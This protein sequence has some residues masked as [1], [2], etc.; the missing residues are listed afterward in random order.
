MQSIMQSGKNGNFL[1]LMLVL[2]AMVAFGGCKGSDGN[3][4]AA[5]AA[6]SDGVYGPNCVNCHHLSAKA[7]SMGIPLR[8]HENGGKPLVVGVTQNNT[9]SFKSAAAGTP[10][11]LTAVSTFTI[12]N[13]ST[14]ATTTVNATGYF[15]QYMDGLPSS[16]QGAADNISM[17]QTVTVTIPGGLDYRQELVNIALNPGTSFDPNRYRVVPI[18]DFT[19]TAAAVS[20]YLLTVFGDDGNVYFDIIGVKASDAATDVAKYAPVHTTGEPV[21]PINLPVLI[22]AQTGSFAGTWTLTRPGGSSAVFKDSSGLTDTVTYPYFTPDVAGTYTVS[23]GV[24]TITVYAGTWRGVITGAPGGELLPA[25]YDTTCTNA[26]HNVADNPLTAWSGNTSAAPDK[27][28]SWSNTG[29]AKRFTQGLNDSRVE[30]PYDGPGN[31]FNCHTVGFV[32]SAAK[33]NG[34]FRDQ[35]NYQMFVDNV[36]T[37]ALTA[38]APDPKRYA[39]AWASGNYNE[40]LKRSN[41][42]C[43]QCHGPQD[44]TGAHPGD[45]G[46]GVAGT[47]ISLDA[48]VCGLCHGAPTHHT[49]YEQWKLSDTGHANFDLAREMTADSTHLTGCAGCHTAQGSL[50]LQKQLVNGNPLQYLPSTFSVTADKVQP[51]TCAVCHDPHN[52]GT[53]SDDANFTP[54]QVTNNGLPRLSLL[55]KAKGLNPGDTPKLPAG[56]RATGVGD[57][58]QCIICHNT[59]NGGVGTT[60]DDGTTTGNSYLHED[61]DPKFG[62]LTSYSAPHSGAQGDVLM[63]H[64]AYFLGSS[65]EDAS[66]YRGN[67]SKIVD[68]CVTCHMEKTPPPYAWTENDHGTNHTFKADIAICNDCHGIDVGLGARL[69]MDTETQL[70]EVFTAINNVIISQA[71]G[72]YKSNIATAS[73]NPGYA[74]TGNLT[75]KDGTPAANNVP[76]AN[77]VSLGTQAGQ[78]LAKAI[79]NY[80]LIVN[81]SSLG[82]HNP[83]FIEN[84]LGTTNSKLMNLQ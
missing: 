9:A 73:Y 1:L 79:W 2:I 25:T 36:V 40:L 82:V 17:D 3:T 55:M 5:G 68:T 39:D 83:A 49:R 50:A 74:V 47:R 32:Q 77:V 23:D 30:E 26:C 80:N 16:I 18:N 78:T 34:G 63:G 10:V 65:G 24:G 33:N 56:F 60:A 43:E 11:G 48:N 52:V 45:A 69:Q 12:L 42:Q 22:T 46:A 29:H 67:H 75:F 71:T 53:E 76:M 6:G 7:I 8:P 14:G 19:K 28:T 66:N 72:T 59:R 81:D 70:G 13:E 51:Q 35:P 57:G 58:G 15:W 27:F 37:P 38:T 64:N 21:V 44:N 61:N 84:V 41:I 54:E 4:G 31:C 62:A 20:R